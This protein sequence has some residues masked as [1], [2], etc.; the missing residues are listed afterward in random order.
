MTNKVED[1]NRLIK[2]IS[3]YT[4]KLKE[5]IDMYN[6]QKRRKNMVILYGGL[7][8][9]IIY[10]IGLSYF[11]NDSFR[12]FILESGSGIIILIVALMALIGF[13][14]YVMFSFFKENRNRTDILDEIILTQKQLNQLIS[15]GSQSREH[16]LSKDDGFVIL[17]FDLKLTEAENIIS[18]AN[19]I[20][21]IN[22]IFHSTFGNPF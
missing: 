14:S 20:P 7:I 17:E 10:A 5:L 12:H 15:I 16:M 21:S 9:I 3:E 13:I 19:R 1:I 22:R 4:N 11:S 8:F 2:L 6:S 18:R